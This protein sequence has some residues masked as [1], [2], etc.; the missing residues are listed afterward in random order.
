MASPAVAKAQA[1]FA[2]QLLRHSSKSEENAFLSPVSI[3]V[4]LAMTFTGADHETAKQMKAVMC[5]GTHTHT[6]THSHT[7]IAG[8]SDDEMH[9]SFASLMTL[10]NAK[11]DAYKLHTANRVYSQEGMEL[12]QG[13]VDKLKKHYNT[14]L[15]LVDFKTKAAAI[16][17]CLFI[18]YL[19][20]F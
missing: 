16:T 14:Q 5:P 20:Y 18:Y 9:A 15:N 7:T 1:D 10:L 13:A 19:F 11:N 4:A 8:V 6:L 12:K 3:A 2:L 17:V